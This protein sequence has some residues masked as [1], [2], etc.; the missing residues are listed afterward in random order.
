MP[1][2]EAQIAANRASVSEAEAD[3]LRE[4]AGKLALF[5]PSKDATL[6][7]KYEA[8]ARRTFFRALKRVARPR[9]G[10]QGGRGG[11]VWR[12]GRGIGFVF[13]GRDAVRAVRRRG[14]NRDRE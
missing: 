5:V 8:E 6:A 1:A 13:G 2:N 14:V 12:A 7:R 11:E 10:C 4:E 3:K 9:E